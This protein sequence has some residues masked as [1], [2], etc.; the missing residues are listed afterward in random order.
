MERKGGKKK[1]SWTKK[2]VELDT[3]IHSDIKTQV[4][5]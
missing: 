1:K 2:I 3:L 5:Y 4:L